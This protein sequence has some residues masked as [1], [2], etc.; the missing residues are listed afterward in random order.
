MTRRTPLTYEELPEGMPIFP[1]YGVLLL[2]RGDLPLNIFEPRYLRMVDSAMKTS[3]RLIGMVQPVSEGDKPDVFPIGCAGR[4][5][6]FE[7][8][9]DG[10]YLINLHGVCRFRVIGEM[11]VAEGGFR[12]ARISWQA[13]RQDMERVG[14]LD[15]DRD[16]LMGLL[17]RYFGL[18]G[19]DLDWKLIDEVADECLM[20]TLAM[21]CP[22]A[23]SE[24]QALLEA[25][26]CYT[27]A[28]MFVNLLEMAIRQQQHMPQTPH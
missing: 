21:V 28:D 15:I 3:H 12:N 18:Q 5:T 17:K 4:I 11:P 23:P 14:C 7:E 26:C 2:P 9:D 19:M 1:L 16:H 10:R 24:K 6:R 13:Y 25:P 20:T 22:F 8:T 27:R